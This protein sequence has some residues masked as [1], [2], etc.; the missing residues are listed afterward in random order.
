MFQTCNTMVVLRFCNEMSLRPFSPSSQSSRAVVSDRHEYVH[1]VAVTLSVSKHFLTAVI[2]PIHKCWKW[3]KIKSNEVHISRQLINTF[4][5]LV[6]WTHFSFTT[7]KLKGFLKCFFLKMKAV[8]KQYV[9]I[10]TV[11]SPCV[12]RIYS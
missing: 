10:N 1:E 9:F 6:Q 3:R 11:K 5:R 7:S 4:L 12:K 2:W 8:A